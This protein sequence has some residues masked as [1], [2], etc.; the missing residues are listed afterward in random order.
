MALQIESKQLEEQMVLF[1]IQGEMDVFSS[2][3][4][5]QKIAEAVE[6]GDHYVIIDLRRV[7]YMDSTG[8]GVLISGLKRTREHGGNI[9]L[10][11]PHHRVR[12]ILKVTGLENVLCPYETLEEAREKVHVVVGKSL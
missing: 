11:A 2:P 10:L 8:L 3:A 6:E 5:K 9:C 4:V 12:K 1:E 7:S